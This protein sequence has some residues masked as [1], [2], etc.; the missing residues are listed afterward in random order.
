MQQLARWDEVVQ[1][2]GRDH[3]R[4]DLARIL[5]HACVDFHPVGEAFRAAVIPLFAL[6]GLV[7]HR[8]PIPLFVLVPP[9]H[10]GSALV[11]MELEAA[12]KVASTIVPCRMVMARAL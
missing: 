12:I 5:V 11:K 7:H 3:H 8:I 1:V 6:L 10:S 4:M 9:A 2:G